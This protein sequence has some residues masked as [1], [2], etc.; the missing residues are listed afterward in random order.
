MFETIRRSV[1]DNARLSREEGLWL[2]QN[3]S[4]LDLAELAETVR[5]RKN[6]K[7]RVTFVIDSNPNYTN[8]CN[9]DCI[10]CAFYRHEGDA[11]TYTHSV[12]DMIARFK[13]AAKRGV[14]T[15]LLQGGVNPAIPFEY[16]LEMVRRTRQEVPEIHPHCFSTSEIIGMGEVSGLSIPEVLAK[17]WEAGLNSIP[18]GGAEILSDR[19]KKKISNRKGTSADWLSV[20]R[21]AHKLGYKSTATMMYG[22]LEKD[23]DII[24][25]LAV[26]RDLQDEYGGF[27]AFVPWSFKP[28]NTPLEKIIPT[29]ATGTRYLQ[30]IAIARIFLDNFDHIQGSWFSEGKKIGQIAL[31]FGADDFGGV[32]EEEN[33]HA[34]ANFVHTTSVREMVDLIRSAGYTPAE[35]TTLY[36]IIAEYGQGEYP[37]A[38]LNTARLDVQMG[39]SGILT[40]LPVLQD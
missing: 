20:M 28:G 19:V 3:A 18:G 15:V 40:S 29:Y 30:M 32:L 25:H 21:E 37:A 27:T 8:I 14:R 22:H 1:S 33:V 36:D 24:E 17:L 4:L 34:S 13:A 5:Y 23:E 39:A 16:Y 6:P 35:R 10:F 38:A 11:D 26:I 2:L 12:D 7:R 9:I 31:A